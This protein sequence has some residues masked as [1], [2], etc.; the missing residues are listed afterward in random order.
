MARKRLG[1]HFLAD[2]HAADRIVG[3]A[4]LGRGDTVL[5]IGPGRGILT[6]RL[7]DAAGRVVA[8]E[9]DRD[10]AQRLSERFDGASGVEIV[11]GDIL[12]V[13]LRAMF[14]GE[15]RKIKIVSNLPYYISTPVIELL[16]RSR[17]FVDSAVLMVQKEVADRLAA[18]PGSRRYG[19]TTLNLALWASCRAVMTVRP[20]SFRPPPEVMSAVV[21]VTFAERSLYPLSDEKL[22]RELTGAAFR[23]RRKMLRNTLVPFLAARGLDGE[24]AR[25]VLEDAGVPL[26]A[27]P[28]TVDV[29]SFVAMTNALAVALRDTNMV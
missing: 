23:Q 18:E 6:E 8:V 28:E 3:F 2:E 5:E 22:F 20:G 26:T 9:L 19:L 12:S 27:R 25:A 16:I 15:K 24:Q 17:D 1:Q 7:A 21:V 14:G 13:D 4:A 10:L 11:A 29:A